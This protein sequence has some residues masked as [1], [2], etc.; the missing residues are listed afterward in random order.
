MA[1]LEGSHEFKPIPNPYI[2]GNPV[3]GQEVF[4][5]REDDFAFLRQ[6][7]EA[8]SEGIVLLFVGA[9]RSGKTSIMFQ[10]LEGR[11]GDQY[12][13][14][15]IDMQLMAGVKNDQE[16]FGRM[17]E[18]TIEGVGDDRL[19]PEYYQFSEGNNPVLTFDSLLADIGKIH[20][21]KRMI[22]LV[23]E[24]EILQT[25][26][27]N[28]ELSGAV[29]SYMAS[30]LESRRMSFCLTGSP[31]LGESQGTDWRR[32]IGK[33]IYR[34][35][36]YL[37]PDDCL[38]LVVEPM[39]GHLN[40][41]EGVLDA[42]YRLT[43]GQ[44]FYTQVICTNV[45]DYLNGEM[46]NNLE[47]DDLDEVVGTIVNNPPPQLIYQWDDFKRDEQIALSLLS[48]ESETSDA[49][50]STEA[51]LQSIKSNNYPLDIK[52]QGLNVALEALYEQNWLER[53]EEGAYHIRMDLLRQWIRRA[54]S[55]WRLVE[56][57]EPQRKK[58]AA[59]F[60]VGAVTLV[61]VGIALSLW[62][63]QREAEQETL[64]QQ[65]RMEAAVI[66]TG[67][68]LV[69]SDL[70]DVDILVDGKKIAARAPALI[71]KLDEGMHAVEVRHEKHRPWSKEVKVTA[72]ETNSITA[73]LE[74]LTG[75]LTVQS[76]PAG[77]QVIVRGEQD[78][79]GTTPI[80]G[81][82]LHTGEYEVVVRYSGY[83]EQQRS[84]VITD[85]Q[86]ATVT[87]N[88]DARVGN[89]AVTSTPD[90]AAI[91]LNGKPTGKQ[92]PATLEALAVGNHKISVEL[93][94]Y[95]RR[96]QTAQ[97]ALNKT[98]TL[99]FN[100]QQLPATISLISEPVVGAGI[101]VD[102]SATPQGLTP[103]T[104]NLT[105]GAHH[106][107]I[108]KEGYEPFVLEQNFDPGKKY[109]PLVKLVPQYGWIRITKPYSGTIV[110]NG[111]DEIELPPSTIERQV[112][113]YSL[114]IKGQSQSKKV[115]VTKNDTIKVKLP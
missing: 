30:V 109:K 52:Q 57:E 77:A 76:Q 16:F 94:D 33:G 34:E 75:L 73:H 84:L 44:P 56:S 12:L 99:N 4:F 71:P 41:G 19:M 64:I 63:T 111:S 28:G 58:R 48:E 104:L 93:T 38:R 110:I 74:R 55:I 62:F 8:E 114:T 95:H 11:L 65:A 15:L 47:M 83:V 79:S 36:S 78:T 49:Y 5:G 61:I 17:A 6:S 105:P 91:F 13:P 89:L 24:A 113:T 26:V 29:L 106:I 107:R 112:G 21:D 68:I 51:L 87:F 69:D 97:I 90:G 42:I 22:F 70:G 10:I 67:S 27:S 59:W 35:I 101:Y 81:L 37:S 100:M 82:P 9:R 86:T 98:A 85:N 39:E 18:L 32:L 20:P 72:G 1:P 7:L 53:N 108:V 40:Y 3:R 31:G 92:T 96:E 66:T 46:H 23:D 54:R 2:T 14:V 80:D 102:Q 60:G 25:K 50:V 88:L 115:T 45:V 43:Y 103:T